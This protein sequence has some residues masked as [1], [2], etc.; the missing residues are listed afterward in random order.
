MRH[1]FLQARVWRGRLGP[2]VKVSV[3]ISEQQFSQP[4]FLEDLRRLMAECGAS[5]ENLI[6]E[7]T[8]DIATHGQSSEAKLCELKDY[9]FDLA[10]D[11]FGTGRSSLSRLCRF[12]IDII[13]IDRSFI[14]ELDSQKGEVVLVQAILSV[15]RQLKMDVVAEGIETQN[16]GARL[17]D[18]G[19]ALGQGY[20]FGRAMPA[21][22]VERLIHR[23]A[24]L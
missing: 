9:G 21:L 24:D 23:T 22:E 7:I 20:L 17:L 12:P 18:L 5:S 10:L 2:R 1:A 13:K 16:Q 3:N 15:A 4:H 14:R 6:L 19:C 11:D 8:E